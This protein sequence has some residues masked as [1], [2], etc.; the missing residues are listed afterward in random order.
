MGQLHDLV[1][2]DEVLNFVKQAGQFTGLLSADT[3]TDRKS[4]V[5][6]LLMILPA[7]YSA[8]LRIPVTEPVYEGGNEKFVSEEE[9]SFVYRKVLSIMGSQ[10]EYLDIPDEEEYDRMELIS[11][12]ISEDLSDIYQDIRDFTELYRNGTDEVMN[13]ALWECRMNFETYWGK[14]ILRVAAALHEVMFRDEDT[15]GRMDR[16]WEEQQGGK[17][18]DTDEW[19]I[20]RRQKDL[21]GESD[22]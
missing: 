8:F 13:D 11:R 22:F 7:M 17:E 20:S 12:K 5:S 19:F 9:W 15:L 16:E 18:I 4:F 21:G 3:D 2:S 14:K 10:N 1:Y 6:A